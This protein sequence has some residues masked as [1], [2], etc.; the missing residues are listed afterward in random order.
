[1]ASLEVIRSYSPQAPAD[2]VGEYAGFTPEQIAA[3]VDAGRSAQRAWWALG[4][5]RRS[6]ALMAGAAALRS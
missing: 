6:A 2:L 4:A 1:M 5:A 3:A